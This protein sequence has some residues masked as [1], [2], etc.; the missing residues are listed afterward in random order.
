MGV[1]QLRQACAS[2]LTIQAVWCH[3]RFSV[4]Q[5]RQFDIIMRQFRQHLGHFNVPA[6]GNGVLGIKSLR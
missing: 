2:W 4:T 1:N 6:L 5:Q 3:F